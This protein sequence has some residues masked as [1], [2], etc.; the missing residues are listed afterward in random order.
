VAGSGG[1]PQTSEGHELSLEMVQGMGAFG[2][3]KV[4][5]PAAIYSAAP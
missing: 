1:A 3:M 5:I 4:A 2:M